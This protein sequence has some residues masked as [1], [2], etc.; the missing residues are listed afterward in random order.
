MEN[1]K[2][3]TSL[4]L[5]SFLSKIMRYLPTYDESD[6]KGQPPEEEKKNLVEFHGTAWKLPER[7]DSLVSI[8]I[9]ISYFCV[10]NKPSALIIIH[11]SSMFYDSANS[12]SKVT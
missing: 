5:V 10:L 11:S 4:N 12:D 8:P 2:N 6:E 3:D 9:P 7:K 1:G